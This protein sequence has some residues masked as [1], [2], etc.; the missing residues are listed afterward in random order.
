MT[1]VK[2]LIRYEL[3]NIKRGILIWVAIA[4]FAF[5]A[6]Q[7]ISSMFHGRF[8]YL[9]LAG[10]IATSWLPL[11]FIMIPVMLIGM[12]VGSSNNDIFMVADISPKEIMLS[13]IAVV[14]IID[15]IFLAVDIIMFIIIGM[16]CGVSLS[17]FLYQGIGY[18]VNTLI[19]FIISSL[20]G[21]FAGQVIEEY[22]GDVF[23]FIIVIVLFIIMCN[24]YKTS[25]SVIPLIDIRMF[26]NSFDTISYDKSYLCHNLFWLFSAVI[27]SVLIYRQISGNVKNNKT[28]ILQRCILITAGAACIF[29]AV[30]IFWIKPVYYNMARRVD[31]VYSNDS[32]TTYFGKEN[33]GYYVDKYTMNLNIGDK[34]KNDCTMEIQ[35]TGDK[36][37]SVELGLYKK[38]HISGVEVN[39]F[40][41]DFERTDHS[42]IVR[43][44]RE[45]KKGEILKINI[46]YEGA[47]RTTWN[48]GEELFFVRNNGMFLADVFEWYPKLNDSRIKEY[49]INIK[50]SG[51][52][53]IYSNIDGTN[54]S[55]G[56]TFQGKD[57]EICL[58]S[59][60]IKERKY[61]GYLF[62]G[63][64]EEIKRDSSCNDLIRFMKG[65]NS[66][67]IPEKN[68]AEIK[69]FI[70]APPVPG[71]SYMDEPYTKAFVHPGSLI[72]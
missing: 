46:S 34:L 20:T 2:A 19:F 56:Y 44:P 48:N 66:E 18:L 39:G 16:M 38:L 43:L 55:D 72:H 33:C 58:I 24:F 22:A 1:K 62:I 3:T 10:F 61:K 26:S 15:S 6:E 70:I 13:K 65:R 31:T 69:K 5:A 60:Y 67:G 47:I 41:S 25:N 68:P 54:K 7:N 45:Y 8:S 30:C 42:F 53:K 11:N 4:L 37:N 50:Y 40:V 9:S 63:N 28:M 52:N 21:L 35:V 23:A 27:L 14:S 57:K 12:K 59:G 64:E 49:T 32:D 71:L 36:I 51:S 17:Y 29:S